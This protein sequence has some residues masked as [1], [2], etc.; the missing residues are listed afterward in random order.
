MRQDEH[1]DQQKARTQVAGM[2]SRSVYFLWIEWETRRRRKEQAFNKATE[3]KKN[4]AGKQK[5]RRSRYDTAETMIHDDRQIRGD[6]LLP[7]VFMLSES[8]L[9][10]I[11]YESSG[12]RS[13]SESW[14]G[15]GEEKGIIV[16]VELHLS[17]S[18]QVLKLEENS[19][20]WWS[21]LTWCFLLLSHLIFK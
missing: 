7:L 15:S 3:W 8:E 21:S 18:L 13:S 11:E 12:R 2:D 14:G 1:F 9:I 10:S 6:D 4:G 17:H 19:K 5:Q 16:R 20:N